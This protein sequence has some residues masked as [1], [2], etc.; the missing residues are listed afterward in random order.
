[1][2]PTQEKSTLTISAM[3]EMAT[4]VV[5]LFCSVICRPLEMIVRPWHGS[6]YQTP[7]V[8]ALSS[9]M[10]IALPVISAAFGTVV[11]MIPFTH[12]APPPGMF[13]IG[14]FSLLYFGLT[15]YHS[16]RIYRRMVRPELEE[17]SEYEGGPLPFIHLIPGSGSFWTTRIVIEPALIFAAATVLQSIYIIEPGLSTYLHFAALC[18][19][20]KEF[21][22]WYR[23]WEFLRR[24]LDMRNAGPIIAKLIEDKAT[25]EDLAPIHLSNF[26]RNIS[27]DVRN[28]A[29][30][31][32]A[33]AF[34]TE[35]HTP[36]ENN[37]TH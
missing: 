23:A 28:T 31:Y 15:F 35:T 30:R 9:L 37:E 5:D 29:A 32:I 3:Q 19:A 17:H 24:I 6:R 1:M 27:P 2:L 36:G 26:P 18:L 14:S 8:I 33:R 12:F 21:I 13:G 4:N 22:S 7:A 25:Q 20:M 10:M 34:S 11:G 16:I